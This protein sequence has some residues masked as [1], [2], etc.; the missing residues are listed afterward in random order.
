MNKTYVSNYV[1]FSHLAHICGVFFKK[2]IFPALT[3][4]SISKTMKC[5]KK[6]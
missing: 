4:L 5:E 2:K 6:I 3:Q 1:L